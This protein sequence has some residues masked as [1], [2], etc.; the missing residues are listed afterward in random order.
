MKWR[1][2]EGGAAG[3]SART[4]GGGDGGLLSACKPM[5]MEYGEP[6]SSRSRKRSGMQLWAGAGGMHRWE[7]A[8]PRVYNYFEEGGASSAPSTVVMASRLL[9]LVFVCAS[10]CGP[11]SSIDICG[12]YPSPDPCRPGGLWDPVLERQA[13]CAMQQEN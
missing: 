5:R 13:G 3:T 4:L 11:A 12:K 9:C 2:M 8:G 6:A 1:C 7:A 10:A